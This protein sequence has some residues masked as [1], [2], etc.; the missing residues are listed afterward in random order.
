MGVNAKTKWII[1]ITKRKKKKKQ[2]NT[3]GNRLKCFSTNLRIFLFLL[4]IYH[5]YYI[6]SRKLWLSGAS[7]L[8]IFFFSFF[9]LIH[10]LQRTEPYTFYAGVFFRIQ[11]LTFPCFTLICSLSFEEFSSNFRE[12][13][14]ND[15]NSKIDEIRETLN[16]FLNESIDYALSTGID[17]CFLGKKGWIYGLFMTFVTHQTL[18]CLVQ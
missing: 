16:K 7:N 5:K 6:F 3:S 8:F 10:W 12:V 13:E 11:I 9:T 15:F 4:S 17:K 1:Y 18:N 14:F 2:Q